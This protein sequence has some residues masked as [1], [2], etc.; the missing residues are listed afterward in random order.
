MGGI[1]KILEIL[2]NHTGAV[3]GMRVAVMGVMLT[4][5]ALTVS[6]YFQTPEVPDQHEVRRIADIINQNGALPAEYAGIEQSF[7]G[8][9]ALASAQDEQDFLSQF[10]G[11]DAA[12]ANVEAMKFS[13]RTLGRGEAGLGMGGNEAT[14]LGGGVSGGEVN[15]PSANV[16]G[17]VRTKANGQGQNAGTEG[18]KE[19]GGNKVNKLTSAT[20]AR[21]SG[22]GSSA[23]FGSRGSASSS[24]GGRVANGAV[25][26]NPVS[27]VNM[28]DVNALSG[29]MPTGSAA[30]V[31]SNNNFRDPSYKPSRDDFKAHRSGNV[32]MSKEADDLKFISKTSA[33][34]AKKRFKSDNEAVT[35]AFMGA[36]GTTITYDDPGAFESKSSL[37]DFDEGEYTADSVEEAVQENTANIEDEGTKRLVARTHLLNMF[38]ALL[39]MVLGA[40]FTIAALVSTGYGMAGA[41]ILAGTMWA[42]CATL[43]GFAIAYGVAYGQQEASPAWTFGALALV[44]AG[45]IGLAFVDKV[46]TFMTGL[47]DKIGGWFGLESGSMSH[48]LGM[49]G[50]L[51]GIFGFGKEVV[52]SIKDGSFE[53]PESEE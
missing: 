41:W 11:G 50:Q 28:P 47:A 1:M 27:P 34:M 31:K 20:M 9:L 33:E 52:T 49:G 22:G 45:I 30:F 42:F 32:Q 18:E 3:S 2:K 16:R 35:T 43:L 21:A 6:S 12:V 39:P 48:I 38:A 19:E 40:F 23:S 53:K 15:D 51:G 46:A 7:S 8:K 14:D 13:G 10:D 25:G 4:S 29:S 26:T 17:A 24:T 44:M 36:R 5:L 37:G